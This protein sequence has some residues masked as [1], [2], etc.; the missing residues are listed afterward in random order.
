MLT[1]LEEQVLM[2]VLKYR[3][4]GY[5][6]NIFQHLNSVNKKRVTVGVVY[7]ILDRLT[8]YG[9]ISATMGPKTP[10]RGGMKK[11]FYQITEVGIE[12]LIESKNVYDKIMDGFNGLI[13]QY[14]KKQN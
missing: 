2:T 3:G 14:R 4:E 8:N 1:K 5:G 6:V 12:A 9:Y 11:K 7:E 13:K 10:V